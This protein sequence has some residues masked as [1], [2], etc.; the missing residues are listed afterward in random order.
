MTLLFSLRDYADRDFDA[1]VELDRECFEPGIAYP[2][3]E[4]RRLLSLVTREGVIAESAETIAG[5]CLGYRAPRGTGRII[6]LDVRA[7]HRRS[8]VGRSLLEETIRRLREAGAGE[9]VLEVDLRNASAIAFYE[10]LGFHRRRTIP[11][12][13]GPDRPGIEMSRE[14]AGP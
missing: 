1:I 2:P 5:F 9:T 13:Y 4:M 3:P 7:D 12:Y 8:G 6:T 10:R 14:S 11:G